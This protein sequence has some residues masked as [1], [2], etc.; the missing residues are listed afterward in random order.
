MSWCQTCPYLSKGRCQMAAQLASLPSNHTPVD[1][2]DCAACKVEPE[3]T[4]DKPNATVARI[5]LNALQSQSPSKAPQFRRRFR[6]AL[7]A[8][9]IAS[10]G[11]QDFLCLHRSP[12][13]SRI[14]QCT[15]CDGGQKHQVHWCHL[16][17]RECTVLAAPKAHD[18]RDGKQVEFCIGCDDR[19]ETLPT[20]ATEPVT[21]KVSRKIGYI[22]TAEGR[23]CGEVWANRFRGQTAFLVCGGPSLART[24][25]SLLAQRGIA[26]AAIN[27]AAAMVRPMLAFMSDPPSKFHQSIFADPAIACFVKSDMLDK[28]TREIVGLKGN[29]E[30]IFEK[31]KNAREYPNVWGFERDGSVEFDPAEFFTSERPRWAVSEPGFNKRSTMLTALRILVDMGFTTIGL[32]GCDFLMTPDNPY[33]FRDQAD[34]RKCESNNRLYSVMHRKFVALRPVL[35][36]GGI[37][38][39]NCTPGGSLEAFERVP[40]EDAVRDALQSVKPVETLYGHYWA[41]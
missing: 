28:H 34:V 33:G 16:K 3:P 10:Y 39:V 12:D 14:H 6:E 40:L 29:G 9:G 37:R 13:Y 24:D 38:V 7:Q 31:Q 17:R 36:A 8:P 35:E 1:S 18:S 26:T 32:V 4:F 19:L 25:L 5:A 23:H 11:V 22:T 20:K 30:P 15:P 27:N 2:T 21:P 41:K